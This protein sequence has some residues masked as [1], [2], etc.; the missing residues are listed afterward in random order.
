MLPDAATS[1]LAKEPIVTPSRIKAITRLFADRKLSRR[2]SL[3]AAQDASP[4][5]SSTAPDAEHGPEM[6]F[7]QSFQSG[8]IAPVTGEAGRYAVTLNN[9]LGQ[10]IYF[11]DRPDRVVGAAPTRQFLD[12]LGFFDDNPPNAAL[13]VEASSGETDLAV[14]ELFAPVYD[15]ATHTVTY[16]MAVL[17]TW[18]DTTDLGFT[19]APAD[20]STFDPEFGAAHLFIDDCADYEIFCIHYE[21]RTMAGSIP[22]SDHDGYCYSWMG[23]ECLP[24]QPWHWNALDATS[25]WNQQCNARFPACDNSCDATNVA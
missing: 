21:T 20:L 9:G 14:V 12:G 7:V 19:G 1:L 4:E 3:T 13:I 11:S 10:T 16:E 17:E 6:L 24:C 2:Q 25:Y 15:D 5:A 8:S 22:S 18:E 23:Y